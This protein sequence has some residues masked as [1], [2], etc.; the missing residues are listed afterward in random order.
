MILCAKMRPQMIQNSNKRIYHFSV[1]V[2]IFQRHSGYKDS[3]T[4]QL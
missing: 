3:R 2:L 1:F 4:Q